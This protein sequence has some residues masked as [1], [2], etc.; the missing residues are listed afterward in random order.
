[1]LMLAGFQVQKVSDV[2]P[3]FGCVRFYE[4]T[5][6]AYEENEWVYERE[7]NGVYKAEGVETEFFVQGGE[8]RFD[9]SF[10]SHP[11]VERLK[12]LH[13]VVKHD[14]HEEGPYGGAF[15]SERDYWAY[16]EGNAFAMQAFGY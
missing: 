13:G 10:E 16:R 3:Y 9:G 2:V 11:V 5:E 7:A 15:A 14:D 1:M 8:I 6:A 12:E 4:M